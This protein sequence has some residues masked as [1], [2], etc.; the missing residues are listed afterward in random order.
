MAM[1]NGVPAGPVV[2][3]RQQA[4]LRGIVCPTCGKGGTEVPLVSF[5]VDGSQLALWCAPCLASFL[6]KFLPPMRHRVEE[7]T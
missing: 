1:T 4:I 2:D 6:A 3:L 7:V 5:Q